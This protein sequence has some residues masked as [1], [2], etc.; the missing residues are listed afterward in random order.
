DMDEVEKAEGIERTPREIKQ[1]GQDENIEHDEQSQHPLFDGCSR[2][3]PKE[4]SEIA[5]CPDA[6]ESKE[7]GERQSNVHGAP[8]EEDGHQLTGD[9][10]PPKL[11]KPGQVNAV[12]RT[13]DAGVCPRGRMPSLNT[14][15]ADHG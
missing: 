14:S 2:P 1:T 6:H 9:C 5:D 10:H 12:Y 13:I 15:G 11:E 3:S 7:G 4:I 8:N